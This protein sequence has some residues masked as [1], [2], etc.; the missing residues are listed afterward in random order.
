MW[1]MDGNNSLKRMRTMGGRKAGDTRVFHES[2]Y[3]LPQDYVNQYANEVRTRAPP[4][5]AVPEDALVEPAGA[6]SDDAIGVVDDITA[7]N[8]SGGPGS[9]PLG[10]P[11]TD[12]SSVPGGLDLS[13]PQ[14]DA[15]LPP[16]PH[17][18]PRDMES[19]PASSTT[20]AQVE[21]DP[22]DGGGGSQSS[23]TK[24]W[25]AAQADDKKRALDVFD[26]T[27]VFASACRHGIL[28]WIVDMVR[29]GEL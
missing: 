29:S 27:G 19:Q 16:S 15:P 8:S 26:E 21:G 25:K 20:E 13:A 18:A 5:H 10:Q 2:D 17:T 9:L 23:C 12:A 1:C 11:C 6:H 22:T 4:K 24:N 28:L 14:A 7:H 3:F